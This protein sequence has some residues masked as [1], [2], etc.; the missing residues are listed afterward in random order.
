MMFQYFRM[1]DIESL[2]AQTIF[3]VLAE[4]EGSRQMA[5]L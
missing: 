4:L 2:I 3:T 1:L 5:S